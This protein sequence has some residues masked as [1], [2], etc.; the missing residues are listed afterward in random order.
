MFRV[1]SGC[2][3]HEDDNTVSGTPFGA[4]YGKEYFQF[5][6]KLYNEQLLD[7]EFAMTKGGIPGKRI[8]G[9]LSGDLPR[10][11]ELSPDALAAALGRP[12]VY[13]FAPMENLAGRPPQLC[14]GCPHID[15]FKAIVEATSQET[16]PI[17]FSDIGCYTLGV[18][19]PYRAVP[20]AW[21]DH[22][23]R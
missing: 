4:K 14:R 6:N 20:P 17:L 1:S 21:A 12:P 11:G 22:P 16:H 8:R 13:A 19:P 5:L 9:K 18:M 2:Q 10:T 15:S 23:Y 3:Y 7:P